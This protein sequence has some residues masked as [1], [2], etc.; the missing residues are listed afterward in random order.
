MS[1]SKFLF[2]QEGK[3][4]QLPT[5]TPQQQQ[6]L[7]QLLGGISGPLGMGFE[8][9]SE[10][11]SGRPE[12]FEA[13]Q[14]PAMRQFEE[15]IVPGIAE[16]FTGMGGGA[17]RSSAFQQALGQAGAGLSERLAAQRA[18]LQQGA[19]GQLSQ[20]LGMGMG[21]KPFGYQYTPSTG[22]FLGGLA[23]GVGMGIGGGLSRLL[24]G[25]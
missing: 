2:G 19:M 14:A 25:L 18:G 7:S 15:Q 12:A 16:R 4:E 5:M 6:L 22:G 20:L 3:M 8:R 13:F 17:Q 23:P 1:I 24:G 10:L 9:L 21:A 11:L